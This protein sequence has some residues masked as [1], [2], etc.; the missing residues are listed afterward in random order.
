MS[1]G[2]TRSLPGRLERLALSNGCSARPRRSTASGA[3]FFEAPDLPQGRVG[4]STLSQLK[5]HS[6]IATARGDCSS[7]SSTPSGAV[8]DA[9]SALS[10]SRSRAL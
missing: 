8:N 9:T 2:G 7:S 4:S 3:K 5:A 1:V 6:A 10:R